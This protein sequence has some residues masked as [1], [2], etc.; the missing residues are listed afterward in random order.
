[1]PDAGTTLDSGVDAGVADAGHD[2]GIIEDAGVVE[3]AGVDAGIEDAGV[4]IIDAG[5]THDDAGCRL[6]SG[7]GATFPLRVMAANLTSGNLQSYDPGHGIRIIQGLRPDVV[8]LQEMNYGANT[9]EAM[10]TFMNVLDAGYR[11]ARGAGQIPNGI[12]SRYPIADAGEWP[13]PRVSNRGFTWAIVDLPGPRELFVVSVHLLTSSASERN[14]EAVS[15]L[16]QLSA[17]VPPGDFLLVGGDFNTEVFSE[18]A[19]STLA[20]RVSTGAPPP[21][22]QAG[23]PYTNASRTKPY[24]QVLVSSCLEREQL[25]AGLVFDSRVYMPLSEVAPVQAGDSAAPSMQHMAVVKDF[26]IQP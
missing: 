8:M 21:S 19:L 20:A 15:L 2:A 22:D 18:S 3:D 24:D 11:Y 12:L 1:M 13:D 26:V 17:N 6:P 23:N 14:L 7:L 16:S 10:D 25:D 4:V 9:P 5:P